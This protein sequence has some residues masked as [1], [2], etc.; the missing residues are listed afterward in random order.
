MKTLRASLAAAT[1]V[2][3]AALLPSAAWATPVSVLASDDT[4]I[5]EYSSL[6][7]P[8]SS[9]GAVASLFSILAN[10]GSPLY[11]SY[12][13]IRFDLSVYGGAHVVGPATIST[14]VQG[15]DFGST[16][17]RSVAI[18]E[19]LTSWSGSTATFN[20][21]GGS[22]GVQD[23]E[24]SAILDTIDIDYPGTGDRYVSWTIAADVVQRWL[25]NPSQNY[26]LLIANLELPNVRDLQFGSRESR[27]APTLAFSVPEPGALALSL[28]GL[29]LAALWRRQSKK[30]PADT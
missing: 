10:G 5:T 2:A 19:V 11:R 9:H 16:T 7:G 29:M 4:F 14:Y 8:D 3:S 27:N 6:G 15:T 25:D 26:G 28:T 1:M 12:P 22:P 13:L 23:G 20:N 17:T 30:V 21:F 24:V 18:R